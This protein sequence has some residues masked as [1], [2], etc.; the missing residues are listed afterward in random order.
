[1]LKFRQA[2]K[3]CLTSKMV[4]DIFFSP[5]NFVRENYVDESAPNSNTNSRPNTLVLKI[6]EAL[7]YCTSHF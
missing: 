2:S 4:C 5:D 6:Y 1:M 3:I 7:E